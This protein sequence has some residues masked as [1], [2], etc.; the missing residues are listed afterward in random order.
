MLRAVSRPTYPGR[1]RRKR[2]RILLCTP[3]VTELPEGVGNAAN[4]V[5]A[6]GGGLADISAG[7]FA[8]LHESA[9][10]DVHIAIP[11][12][13][14]Q[15]VGDASQFRRLELDAPKW[16]R[17]GIH[18]VADSAFTN[19]N[20]VY[21][22]TGENSPVRRSLAF[23]R[24]V[25]NRFLDTLTPDLVHCNDWMTGL[26]PAACR[27]R[28]IPC[29]FTIH[30][31]FTYW[32][33][34]SHIDFHGIDVARL[35]ENFWY[36]WFPS[37]KASDWHY[38]HIDFASS[39]VLS[40]DV[41]NTVSPTFAKEVLRGEHDE[42]APPSLMAA[43]K[44]HPRFVGIL[45]APNDTVRADAPGRGYT[46]FS[47]EDVIAGK[48]R[49]KSDLQRAVGLAADPKRPLFFWPHRL[50][51]QKS[52]E[53][54]LET[55]DYA[56]ERKGAQL[57]V[58]ANGDRGLEARFDALA[59]SRP[60]AVARKRFDQSLS[61]LARAGSD[62]MLMPSRYEPCGLPQ[63]ECPRFGTLPIVRL[64]GGLADTITELGS[65]TG[66]GFVFPDADAS[67]LLAAMMRATE[68]H[69]SPGR[70]ATLQRVMRDSM[71]RFSLATTTD[72]YMRVYDELL[73]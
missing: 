10:F 20:Q 62:F 48:A 44:S 54:I 63:L 26:V 69:A 25:I 43:I 22:Q 31:L 59:G 14:R 68:F 4:F 3:E 57:V 41:V 49:N 40:A 5:H 52:P 2:P 1:R 51:G 30:N 38:N 46:P 17:Q 16:E 13:D 73:S 64:T 15:F 66:N 58:V 29:V 35:K 55:I 37:D 32:S 42:W 56:I 60:G 50:Y 24:M 7:L 67:Q 53:L 11:K 8:H 9:D 47:V 23:Q 33:T 72:A 71:E 21:E 36:Q 6:K 18:L 19:L 12:Y 39:G 65:G 45:N 27:D 34:P 70:E 28:G 61:D